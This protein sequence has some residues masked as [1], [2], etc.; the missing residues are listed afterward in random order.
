MR[1][2]KVLLAAAAVAVSSSAFAQDLSFGVKAGLN[3]SKQAYKVGGTKVS[4]S[5]NKMLTGI[6]IGAYADLN[7]SDMLALEAGLQFEQ[8]GGKMK[9]GKETEKEVINYFTIPVNL[10]ANLPVGDNNLYFL[11]GPTF[12][13]GLSGKETY[14]DEDGSESASAKF[15]NGEDDDCKRINVGLLFGAGF[16]MSNNIGVR[17]TYDLGLSNLI[18][19]GDSDNSVKTNVLGLAVTYKF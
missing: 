18:P 16:E 8:K 14:E 5:D 17:V 1:K 6:C 7:F 12:G 2:L 4:S 9:S 19:K 10:R 15:G 3:L 13:I 11:A